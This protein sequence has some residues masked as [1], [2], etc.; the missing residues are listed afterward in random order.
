MYVYMYL[1]VRG[2]CQVSF[3]VAVYHMTD[4]GYGGRQGQYLTPE[5]DG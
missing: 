2:G 4:E 3:A 5:L 1:E